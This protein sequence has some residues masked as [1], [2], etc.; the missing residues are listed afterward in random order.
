M[1]QDRLEHVFYNRIYPCRT[2]TR[3]LTKVRR[4]QE[5]N[6]ELQKLEEEFYYLMSFF[7]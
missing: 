3:Y 4:S 5:K 7:S 2:R 6:S 1:F